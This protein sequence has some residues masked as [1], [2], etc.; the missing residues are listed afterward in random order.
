MAKLD[1]YW[2]QIKGSES[3]QNLSDDQKE[4]V[5]SHLFDRYV[6]KSPS[7]TGLPQSQRIAVKKHFDDITKVEPVSMMDTLKKKAGAVVEA[8]KKVVQ[9]LLDQTSEAYKENR[10]YGEGPLEAAGSVVGEATG[11]HP[12]KI[13]DT[14]EDIEATG[15]DIPGARALAENIHREGEAYAGAIE[16]SEQR[17]GKLHDKPSSL[18]YNPMSQFDLARAVA[19]GAIRTGFDFLSDAIPKTNVDVGL[20]GLTDGLFKYAGTTFLGKTRGLPGWKP[21]SGLAV[22]SG[23]AAETVGDQMEK[24]I[25]QHRIENSARGGRPAPAGLLKEGTPTATPLGPEGSTGMH[26]GPR[27]LEVLAN[28]EAKLKAKAEVD[29]YE[30]WLKAADDL[31]AR[32]GEPTND[33]HPEAKTNVSQ[34]RDA[35]KARLEKLQNEPVRIESLGKAEDEL[36]GYFRLQA[37][38]T[39]RP[40]E[41]AELPPSSIPAP[42]KPPMLPE[43]PKP[44]GLLEAGP[45]TKAAPAAIAPESF[46]ETGAKGYKNYLTKSFSEALPGETHKTIDTLS[47]TLLKALQ[48]AGYVHP[49]K[50]RPLEAD[51]MN[52][53]DRFVDKSVEG[54]IEE[55]GSFSHLKEKGLSIEEVRGRAK[56]LQ[57][58]SEMQRQSRLGAKQK[59]MEVTGGIGMHDPDPATGQIPEREEYLR[60]VSRDLRGKTKPDQAAQMAHDAGLIKGPSSNDLYAYTK[61]LESGGKP[62]SVNSFMDQAEHEIYSEMHKDSG[63]DFGDNKDIKQ[64]PAFDLV[65]EAWKDLGQGGGFESRGYDPVRAA[66]MDAN[67][68][69]LVDRAMSLG[70]ETTQDIL[71]YAAKNAPEELQAELRKN[72]A[73][74]LSAFD[75]HAYKEMEAARQGNPVAKKSLMDRATQGYFKDKADILKGKYRKFKANQAILIFKD[76]DEGLMKLKNELFIHDNYRKFSPDELAAQ[77]WYSEGKSPK[78]ESL[79]RLGMPEDVAK[80]RLDLARN[81]TPQ[82]VS[83]RKMTQIF[84]DEYHDLAS[85]FYDKLGYVEDHVTRRWKQPRE[86]MDWEGRTLSN[87][88]NFAKGRKFLTQADGVDAGHE[89]VSWDI[90]DDLRASNHMRVNVMSRI[91]AYQKLGASFG[92]DGMGAIIDE[93]GDEL[94]QGKNAKITPHQ[95]QAPNSWLRYDH[96]PL[97]KGLA[98]H[99]DFEPVMKYL[100]AR[101][102]KGTIP[103]ILDF[104]AASTKATKLIGMFHSYS[105]GEMLGSGL[106]FRDWFSFSAERNNITRL[107]RYTAKAV[108]ADL[109]GPLNWKNPTKAIGDMYKSFMSGHGALA[110]RP[111]ALDMAEHGFKFGSAD[112]E[113]EG[114]LGKFLGKTEDFLK[115][116]IGQNPSK[117][118]MALPRGA[119]DVQEKLLWSY[120]RPIS[121]MMVYE[122]NVADSIKKFN[123]DAPEGK[124]IPVEQ[125]KSDVANQTSKEMGG[126]SY[127]RLMI[128][129]KTQ[130]VLQWAMLAPGWTIGRALM[131]ASL[132]SKGPEGRQAR[133]Q[134]TKLFVGWYFSSNMIN[135]SQTK[136]YL[137]KGRWMHENPEGYQNQAFMSKDAKGEKYIQLSKALTEIYDDLMHPMRTLAYKASPPVQ[138]AVKVMNWATARSYYPGVSPENPGQ[139]L[140]HAYEPGLVSGM[141]AYGGLPV[142]RGPSKDK[143]MGMLDEYHRTGNKALFEEAMQS[144]TE[145]G[146]DVSKLDR[147]VRGAERAKMK[148]ELFR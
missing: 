116:R 71:L 88:P 27:P 97:L 136:K 121:S 56:R 63:F 1:A 12:G 45:K 52:M 100:L 106:R 17:L 9:P 47:G 58:E 23:S 18:L 129:P 112:E 31:S 36:K 65:K 61:G 19:S 146:Y 44:A 89:P 130:Q 42:E 16:P 118:L 24:L 145:Q 11:I 72:L 74:T 8:G 43:G 66:R 119:L 135:Y 108:T 76:G 7:Y 139:A 55:T 73:P 32:G 142:H 81:P 50:P 59:L 51:V 13:L 90:R 95:G 125:I 10:K 109:E 69:E 144:A 92:P 21:K 54:H 4:K 6:Q 2:N 131:G 104:A 102:F 39:L 34:L 28:E 70:Y 25:T 123:L 113:M 60:N 148:K 98:I 86:Y 26:L 124:K 132:F 140:L 53:L 147:M 134:M 22:P 67:L 29:G 143:I 126:I 5:R 62:R 137:G 122:N 111:L 33:I 38:Q 99:P 75:T 128:D 68:K 41:V 80:R 120:Q 37:A 14:K 15:V 79:T 77:R 83:A 107:L 101:P 84:E 82:M 57:A 138:A 105:L 117:L 49:T 133:N 40:G 78:L 127:A 103:E 94:T 20:W 91:H 35:A 87:K 141:S 115:K 110:N 46:G 85:Q 93:S 30:E 48:E 64:K 3:F 96:V 114:I